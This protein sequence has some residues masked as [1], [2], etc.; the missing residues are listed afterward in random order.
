MKPLNLRPPSWFL[1]LQFGGWVVLSGIGLFIFG[2]GISPD[3]LAGPFIASMGVFFLV[4]CVR[5][6]VRNYRVRVILDDTTM[7]I[8]GWLWSRRIPRDDITAVWRGGHVQ[9]NGQRGH[10]ESVWIVWL[11]RNGPDDDETV[12][13]RLQHPW[14]VAEAEIRQWAKV[15]S[16]L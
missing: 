10:P 15:H 3:V 16:P 1:H 14:R 8:H 7:T 13:G 2:V 5:A 6:A 4:P 11:M 9:Y 12:I